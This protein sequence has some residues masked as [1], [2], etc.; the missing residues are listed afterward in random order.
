MRIISNIV[1]QI[2]DL[3]NN[4]HL[5]LLCIYMNILRRVTYVYTYLLIICNLNNRNHSNKGK[6][7]RWPTS[8][9]TIWWTIEIVPDRLLNTRHYALSP[10]HISLFRLYQHLFIRIIAKLHEIPLGKLLLYRMK[11]GTRTISWCASRHTI[12]NNTRIY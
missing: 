6:M 11:Y 12:Y 8:S 4:S 2:I 7:T 1:H 9:P 5:D 10:H 3:F